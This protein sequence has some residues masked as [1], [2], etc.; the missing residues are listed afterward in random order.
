MEKPFILISNDDGIN[1][2]GI[3]ALANEIKKIAEI[4]IV[5]PDTQQSAVGHALTTSSPLR[6]EFFEKN[7]QYFGYAINGTPGDC[8]KLGVRNLVKKRPDLVISG[9]NHGMNTAINVIYSGTVS[10]AT[11]AAI[12]GIPS[13]AISLGTFADN[14]DFSF[15]AKFAR[16]FAPFFL[17]HKLPK[18]TLLN[19]NV[20]A[21][22]EGEIK[23][24]K[25]TKQNYSYWDDWFEERRDPQNKL[26]YWLTGKYI[27][28]N[29]ELEYD[30][31]AINNN[32]VS[33]TPIHYDLTNYDFLKT[34]HKWNL[35][36]I[37][38]NK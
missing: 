4:M 15:A 16:L 11:E 25:T 21:V 10:A 13:F 8:V 34:M 19:I 29:E 37:I 20:P 22:P 28:G 30:D 14:P 24:I 5:A 7:G 18:G 36:T 35:N 3:Y 27:I 17:E 26:Y 1:A 12:L 32:Y 31:V 23:G 33:I 6:S 2:P 38:Q 9:I